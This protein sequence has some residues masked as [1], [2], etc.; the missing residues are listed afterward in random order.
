MSGR[1]VDLE[2]AARM[3]GIE[4]LPWQRD[5]ARRLLAGERVVLPGG[6]Q[7]GRAT[8]RRVLAKATETTTAQI[9]TEAGSPVPVDLMA[10]WCETWADGDKRLRAE[11]ISLNVFGRRLPRTPGQL[12]ERLRDRSSFGCVTGGHP[13]SSYLLDEGR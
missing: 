3:L 2:K 7:V 4:L 5:F 10:K 8:L 12:W 11:E 6:K 9:V 13:G 1:Q